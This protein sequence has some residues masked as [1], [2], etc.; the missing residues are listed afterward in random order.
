[1]APTA[2]SLWRRHLLILV[3]VVIRRRL[4]ARAFNTASLVSHLRLGP[5]IRDDSSSPSTRPSYRRRHRLPQLHD[6]A[7]QDDIDLDVVAEESFAPDVLSSDVGDALITH[8]VGGKESNA[9]AETATAPPSDSSS[10]REMIKFALPALGIFLAN[11]L[12]SNID[13]AFVGRTAGAAGLAALSPAT[14]CTDQM[15][16]LFS[17][18]ARAMTGLV[19]RAYASAAVAEERGG[20]V[21]AARDA[22]SAP[23][24]VSLACG[25]TLTAMYAA[26]TP[27]LLSML[28]VDAALL[29]PAASYV[30]W[31]G[32]VAAAALAQSVSLSTLLATRDAVTPLVI[33]AS[34]AVLNVVGDALFCVYPFRWGCAGAA[35]ATSAATLVSSGFMLRALKAKRL[36][37][38]LHVPSKRE[39][40]NLLE[41]TGPLLAITITRLVGFVA[42]QRAATDLG[43]LPLAGYQVCINVVIFFLLFAEPLSQLSQTKLPALVDRNDG[44]GALAMIKNV[45]VLG[46][47]ASLAVGATAFSTV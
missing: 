35:A 16:Y 28:N 24:T 22:A 19:S 20:D 26:F 10:K 3:F 25:L 13:N 33:V 4:Y 46:F 36:L 44:K 39:M 8:P 18:L 42:M 1:M 47:G 43:V 11:P 40:M 5:G 45:L 21:E 14:I 9:N 12:L 17:F 2:P 29:R 23:L 41:F 15:L 32:L 27:K 31:R 30:R 34:A 7:A 6:A 38:S 37:P